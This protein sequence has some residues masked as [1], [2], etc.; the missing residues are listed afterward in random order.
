MQY[1]T[2]DPKL[3]DD[4]SLE[5]MLKYPIWKMVFD[6]AGT[7]ENDVYQSP[8]IN[9]DNVTDDFVDPFILLKVKGTNYYLSAQYYIPNLMVHKFW[10]WDMHNILENLP[11]PLVLIA[12]PLINGMADVEFKADDDFYG[13]KIAAK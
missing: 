5:D 12:V 7:D 13:F 11:R 9:T 2:G 3:I 4:V 1:I 10:G 8:I 6:L